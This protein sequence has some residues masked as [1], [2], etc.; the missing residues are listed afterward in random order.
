MAN[1]FESP[2]DKG[3]NP[4][5]ENQ[6]NSFNHPLVGEGKKYATLEAAL[7]SLTPAQE[8]INKLEAELADLRKQMSDR[9]SIEQK[10]EE[11]AEA[12][13]VPAEKSDPN[14]LLK[15]VDSRLAEKEQERSIKANIDSVVTTLTAKFGDEAKAKAAYEQKAAE[16]GVSVGTLTELASKSPKAVL[17]YFNAREGS[18]VPTKTTGSVNTDALDTGDVNGERDFKYWQDVRRKNEKH[19]YSSGVQAQMR[20]DIERL[21]R[22]RFFGRT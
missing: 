10:L 19:Y 2:S 21:G 22:D 18:E 17:S 3:G 12:K 9:E 6:E 16:L 14:D 13:R 20:Q 4:E 1:P 5:T 11:I 15:L 7:D 8:H